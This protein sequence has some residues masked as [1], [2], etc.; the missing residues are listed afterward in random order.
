VWD[1]LN[2]N[3]GSVTNSF[4]VLLSPYTQK[5]R[6]YKIKPITTAIPQ[7]WDD[8]EYIWISWHVSSEPLGTSALKVEAV[9]AVGT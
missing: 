5:F 6:W 1:I 9:G 7:E 3:L 8:C 2:S 4:E